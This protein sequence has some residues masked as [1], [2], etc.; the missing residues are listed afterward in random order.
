ME[1]KIGDTVFFKNRNPIGWEVRPITWLNKNRLYTI[2]VINKTY[3]R[4]HGHAAAM[5]PNHFIK[6][7]GDNIQGINIFNIGDKVL[8]TNGGQIG[9][10]TTDWTRGLII[11]DIYEVFKFRLSNGQS[12]MTVKKGNG[13]TLHSNH[14]IKYKE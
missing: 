4:L 13:H 11:G 9:W 12:F 14:F 2:S 1:F 8:F 7:E 10:E 5:H 3:V 6:V